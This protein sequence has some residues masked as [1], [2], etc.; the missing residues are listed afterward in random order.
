VALTVVAPDELESDELY[1]VNHHGAMFIGVVR[2]YYPNGQIRYEACY[3]DG[4]E[5]GPSRSWTDSGTQTE[6]VHF[7]GGLPHGAT[8]KWHP[9]GSRKEDA[10]FEHGSLTR[11]KTWD[12]SGNETENYTISAADASAWSSLQSDRAFYGTEPVVT[13]D[14]TALEFVEV[15]FS[16]P[17]FTL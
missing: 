11:L 15:S 17:G 5:H 1:Y 12:E 10:W 6:E 2:D 3:E 7:R 4:V 14:P 16:D 8:F 13:L 9:D